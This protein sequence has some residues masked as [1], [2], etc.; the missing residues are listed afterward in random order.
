MLN[1]LLIND[2]IFYLLL[3]LILSIIIPNVLLKYK[4]DNS[5]P[6]YCKDDIYLKNKT[7]I[8]GGIIFILPFILFLLFNKY[9]KILL[10]LIPSTLLGFIDDFYKIK[11][12]DRIKGINKYTKII[13]LIINYIFYGYLFNQIFGL[14]EFIL[15]CLIYMGILFIDGI[16]GLLGILSIITLFFVKYFGNSSEIINI[17]LFSIIPFILV[18]I[19]P[20]KIFMGDTGS[21]FLAAILYYIIMKQSNRHGF[22]SIYI[23]TSFTTILQV[24]SYQTIKKRV[25]DITPYHH[26]LQKRKWTENQIVILYCILYT[27]IF[28]YFFN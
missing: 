24:I 28:F 26:S 8:L 3:S 25:F 21:S 5:L 2:S 22:A 12:K 20:A 17:L 1:K 9:Y 18:N 13:F 11:Y 7:P 10:F 23:L 27:I 14:K 6:I 16:D 15:Y 19:K 4:L